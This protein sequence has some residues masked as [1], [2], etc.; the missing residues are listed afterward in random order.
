MHVRTRKF[1]RTELL[2]NNSLLS[3]FF[4]FTDTTPQ[5]NYEFVDLNEK[6]TGGCPTNWLKEDSTCYGLLPGSEGSVYLARQKCLKEGHD[7]AAIRSKD[8]LDF[9]EELI[10]ENVRMTHFFL[11]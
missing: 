3:F 6:C 2:I 7:L 9:I 11:S 10:W 4:S 1:Y 8:Q 5:A